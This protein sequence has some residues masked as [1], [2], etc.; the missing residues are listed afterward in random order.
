MPRKTIDYSKSEIY[1]LCCKDTSITDCYIGCTTDFI[2]RK[3][4][5]KSR[6][7]NE[8]NKCH[9]FKV[10]KFIRDNGGWNNW[11]MILL[12]KINVNNGNELRKEER[13]WVE[14][15]NSTL[16]HQLPG[17]TQKEYG[18]EYQKNNREK[19]NE[20]QRRYVQKN[21]EKIAE[22]RR[23][24]VEC[25][26]CSSIISLGGLSRHQKTMKCLKK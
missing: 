8:S 3:S 18:K 1:K 14:E 26:I 10:Y 17:R 24:K 23:E 22:R 9:H 4:S 6:C 2:T 20:K 11:D 5:H 12:E 25:P 16:N 21:K 7:N 19:E 13:R 15:L